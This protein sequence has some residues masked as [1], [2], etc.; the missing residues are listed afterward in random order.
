MLAVRPVVRLT[1][2][3]AAMVA[4]EAIMAVAL[5]DSM[6]LSISP[7][8][9][10]PKVIL[11]LLLSFAPFTVVAR[12]IGPVIQRFSGGQRAVIFGVA[13]IRAVLMI[14]MVNSIH[15]LALFP[16]AFGA[17]VLSKTYSI[18]KSAMVPQ[19]VEGDERLVEANSNL[20]KVAG[21][22]GFAV[23]VP[24]FALQAISVSVTLY[25]GTLVFVT[26]AVQA[27][28]LPR[29]SS[30]GADDPVAEQ[31]ELHS[32]R[33]VHAANTMRF[34][35][36]AVGFMFFHL[37]FWLRSEIAG[38]AWFAFA[39]ALGNM[40]ILAANWTAPAL[41]AR[42][43]TETM[44]TV[45]LA[46]V[47]VCG[48][49]AGISG[50]FI[51]GVLLTAVVNAAAAIGRV[52]FEATVQSGASHADKVSAF[53]RFETHNQL[54]WVAGGLVPVILRLNGHA[55]SWFV[56]VLGAVGMLVMLRDRGITGSRGAPATGRARRAP[57]A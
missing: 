42:L 27:W 15:S 46:M 50:V 26:A 14:G 3:H 4:G 54:A 5:A 52:A 8:D 56:G 51:A 53:A 48:I 16:L 9:A 40:S 23:G 34:L 2:V 57:R 24:A 21:I 55:G 45:S 38:T 25:A 19:L 33:V 7:T 37:A 6:F 43:R 36:G 32:P 18:S 30:Q 39:V 12:Y 44:L 20:A 17:L 31:Q 49:A 1:R 29:T 10:R 11:F 28:H 41:R 22:I 47:A 13:L 35:R